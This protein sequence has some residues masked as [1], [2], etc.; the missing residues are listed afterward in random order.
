MG[1]AVV[2]AANDARR[3][4][5][6]LAAEISGLVASRAEEQGLELARD[7]GP[8]LGQLKVD[9]TAL[10]TA[11]VNILENAFD[12]CRM[13]RRKQAHRVTFSVHANDP[14][15][16]SFEIADTGIGM[17]RETSEK[18]FSLFFSSKGSEGTGLG[19]F[20]SN[21]IVQQLGG[22]MALESTP[23]VGTHFRIRIP[24]TPP[25]PEPPGDGAQH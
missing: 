25:P 19:L 10:R 14:G 4:V 12:A 7:F 5:L 9:T 11:L 24:R 1:N 17:D 18:A 3:Q 13:D 20:I 23:D 21:K 2:A 16:L 8:A 6:E 22:S 15:W